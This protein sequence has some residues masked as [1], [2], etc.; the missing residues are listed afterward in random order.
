[1]VVPNHD[2]IRRVHGSRPAADECKNIAPKEHFHSSQRAWTALCRRSLASKCLPERLAVENSEAAA[3]RQHE[4]AA[5]LFATSKYQTHT[6]HTFHQQSASHTHTSTTHIQ[7]LMHS[8]HGTYTLH[9]THLIEPRVEDHS[10]SSFSSRLS[11]VRCTTHFFRAAFS[12]H[13]ACRLVSVQSLSA[14]TSLLFGF[15][16]YRSPYTI[17]HYNNTSRP[18]IVPTRNNINVRAIK[19]KSALRCW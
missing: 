1:M 13:S 10:S 14:L 9:K 12:F 16:S 15:T 19:S 11:S 3:C 2:A 6:K 17:L 18:T 8:H 7:A 4:A 5:V